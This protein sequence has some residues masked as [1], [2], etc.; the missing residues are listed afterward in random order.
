MTESS[1][2]KFIKN[3]LKKP[4]G[5]MASWIISKELMKCDERREYIYYL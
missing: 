2:R 4:G 1:I 5:S 3:E